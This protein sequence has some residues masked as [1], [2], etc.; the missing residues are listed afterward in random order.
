ME[1][2]EAGIL[3][4]VETEPTPGGVTQG[5]GQFILALIPP[6]FINANRSPRPFPYRLAPLHLHTINNS[7]V[8]RSSI[9]CELFKLL[10]NSR[11]ILV[12][13]LTLA[14]HRWIL[15]CQL[16]LCSKVN[17]YSTMYDVIKQLNIF[18]SFQIYII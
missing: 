9:A 6:G 17:V 4:G 2:S 12:H 16:M 3:E 1:E 8:P 5:L 10:S 7:S 14:D 13:H 11:S 18:S 15:T